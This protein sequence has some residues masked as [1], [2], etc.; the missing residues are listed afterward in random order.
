MEDAFWEYKTAKSGI[1]RPKV[2]VEV[3]APIYDPNA[4]DWN[5]QTLRNDP[6]NIA[7]NGVSYLSAKFGD[8]LQFYDESGDI[9]EAYACVPGV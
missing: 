3:E 6:A 4:V 2:E 8:K 1:E 9:V 5:L 7:P